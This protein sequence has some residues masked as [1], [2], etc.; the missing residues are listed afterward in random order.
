MSCARTF[1]KLKR[2]FD[3]AGRLL[4]QERIL[5]LVHVRLRQW[6]GGRSVIAV[7]LSRLSEEG[8]SLGARCVDLSRAIPWEECD[9]LLR[10]DLDSLS[11]DLVPH[12][13]RQDQDLLTAW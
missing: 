8:S 6:L 1:E 13:S 11:P 9:Q 10:E 5:G 3:R 4:E 2:H 7:R 12:G